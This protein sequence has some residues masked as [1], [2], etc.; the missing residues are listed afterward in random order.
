MKKAYFVNNEIYHDSNISTPPI[1]Y[2]TEKT[3]KL[4]G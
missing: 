2:L 1:I 3:G 4:H